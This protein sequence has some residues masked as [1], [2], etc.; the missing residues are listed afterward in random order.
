MRP[1]WARR[2]APDYERSVSTPEYVTLICGLGSDFL[3]YKLSLRTPLLPHHFHKQGIY[4][5][6]PP[7]KSVLPPLATDFLLWS[8]NEITGMPTSHSN[9]VHHTQWQQLHRT[10]STASDVKII[11][12]FWPV[13]RLYITCQ[14]FMCLCPIY[15]WSSG[16]WVI[17]AEV[18]LQYSINERSWHLVLQQ[19]LTTL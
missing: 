6:H 2:I 9:V 16:C 4:C 11:N 15:N 1:C 17:V 7:I 18:G 10:N 8:T 19:H 14:Q 13:T 3:P 12:F 5:F